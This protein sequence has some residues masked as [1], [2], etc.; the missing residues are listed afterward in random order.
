MTSLKK[1][2]VNKDFELINEVN[3]LENRDS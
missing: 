2:D 3:L 1:E